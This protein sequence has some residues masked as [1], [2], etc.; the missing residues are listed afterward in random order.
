MQKT[1]PLVCIAMA[2]LAL[3]AVAATNAA[4]AADKTVI[5]FS[6]GIGSRT[7]PSNIAIQQFKTDVEAAAPG[8]IE[9]Q[10]FYGNQLGTLQ[11][12]AD[13]VKDGTIQM[14][15]VSFGFLAK[16]LPDVQAVLLPFL[17]SDAA[18]AHAAYDGPIGQDIKDKLAA[19]SGIRILGIGEFGFK[20]VFNSKRPVVTM[21]DLAGLK[22]RVVP[23]PITLATFK[24]LGAVPVSM[25]YAETYTGIQR[26]VIDGAE[27]AY[28]T[29][30]D[31]KFYETAKYVSDTGHFFEGYCFAINEKFLLGLPADLQKIIRD[32][33]I[34]LQNL[35]RQLVAKQD[36]EAKALLAGKGM[37][38]TTLSPAVRA[39]MRE[40]VRPVYEEAKT[41][42][43]FGPDGIRWIDELTKTH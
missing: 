16:Y 42:F 10:I 23:T 9:V 8:R 19:K 31:A 22:L 11:D 30:Y 26:G 39:Q 21:Q 43:G 20:N 14:N 41:K 1:G 3:V 15:S 37:T 6:A 17:F 5:R 38:L 28:G 25:D 4:F 18:Q 2:L 34:K 27:F 35:D 29:I 13:Q 36:Q 32:S 24:A 40:A 33:A 7:D 12:V